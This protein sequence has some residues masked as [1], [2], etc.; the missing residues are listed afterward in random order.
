MLECECVFMSNF[1]SGVF[2]LYE[3]GCIYVTSMSV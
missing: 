2:F 1:F 3:C